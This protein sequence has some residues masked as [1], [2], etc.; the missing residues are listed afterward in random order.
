MI[1][2]S[3]ALAI[4]D[5]PFN[6]PVGAVRVGYIDGSF[7]IN[8]GLKEIEA[9]ALNLVIAGTADA[10]MMVEGG[11]NELTEDQMLEALAIGHGEIKKVVA[12]QNDLVAKVGKAKP[13]S[14]AV[15]TITRRNITALASAIPALRSEPSPASSRSLPASE[16]V[17]AVEETIAPAAAVA[18]TPREGPSSLTPA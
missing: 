1:A 10:I 13:A 14:T 3:A 12:L 16:A 18:S 4:S 9:S 5:I 7:R 15:S 6:G 11:A 17:T 8:P 2:S